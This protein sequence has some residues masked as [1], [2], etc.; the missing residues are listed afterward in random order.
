M[1]HYSIYT[2]YM[3]PVLTFP[4]PCSWAF[5]ASVM[6]SQ[7]Y[8]EGQIKSVCVTIECDIKCLV[9]IYSKQYIYVS[10]YIYSQKSS[11][12]QDHA[13]SEGSRGGPS[14]LPLASGGFCSPWLSLACC[15]LQAPLCFHMVFSPVCVC[16][17]FSSYKDTRLLD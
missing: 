14:L 6:T 2:S 7:G 11:C 13:L 1:S 3:D 4:W 10:I 15:C 12:W 5:W 17:S 16:L 8:C 9:S